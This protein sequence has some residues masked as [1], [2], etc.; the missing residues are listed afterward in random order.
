MKTYWKRLISD[1]KA[2]IIGVMV[3][4]IVSG[5][6]KYFRH[7]DLEENGVTVNGTIIECD[8]LK[9]NGACVVKIEYQTFDGITKT[10]TNTLYSKENCE[11]GKVVKLRYSTETDITNVIE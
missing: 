9:I 3:I 7:T 6:I 10:S 5:S 1:N 4:L 2:T 11:L 8:M